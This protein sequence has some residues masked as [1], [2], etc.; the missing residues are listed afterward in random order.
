M[1]RSGRV[2]RKKQDN[3]LFCRACDSWVGIDGFAYVAG[4]TFNRAASC[5]PCT[6]E[7]NRLRNIRVKAARDLEKAKGAPTV[8]IL[9]AIP[10][11]QS[12]LSNIMACNLWNQELNFE[13]LRA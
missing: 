2:N 4:R 9:P 12:P 3:N 8:I 11:K 1:S 7:R 10:Y 13:R 6:K 5:R